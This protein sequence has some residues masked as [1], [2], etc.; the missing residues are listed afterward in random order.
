TSSEITTIAVAIITTVV[1]PIVVYYFTNRRYEEQKALTEKLERELTEAKRA[2]RG[3]KE[4]SAE[5]YGIKIVSPT[6]GAQL[7]GDSHNFSGT[8]AIKPADGKTVRLFEMNPHDRHY[9]TKNSAV[10][11]DEQRKTWHASSVHVGGKPGETK[12]MAI[13]VMGRAGEILALYQ[14]KVGNLTGQWP[15]LETFTPDMIECDSIKVIKAQSKPSD[16]SELLISHRWVL[17]HNPPD[18]SKPIT[19]LPDGTVGEGQNQ[20]EHTWRVRSGR[21]ELLQGDGRVH[22]RFDFDKKATRFIHTN[23]PDTLSNRNQFIH[24]L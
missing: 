14:H 20:N 4:L 16:W 11:F 5:D 13:V 17:V 15:G 3:T 19:F 12:I 22:S 6:M 7:V 24:L 21:L 9:W 18:Q 1:A 8:H 2:S 23:D 10:I